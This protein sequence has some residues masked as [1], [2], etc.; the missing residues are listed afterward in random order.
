MQGYPTPHRDIFCEI[1]GLNTK[2]KTGCTMK[3]CAHALITF[4]SVG[5]QIALFKLSAIHWRIFKYA[6]RNNLERWSFKIS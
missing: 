6:L 2:L 5:L 3:A 1:Y 4:P